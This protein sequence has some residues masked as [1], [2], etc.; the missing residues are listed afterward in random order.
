MFVAQLAERSLPTSELRGL[1]PNIGKVFRMLIFVN[2]NSEKAKIKKKGPGMASLKKEDSWRPTYLNVVLV[3]KSILF[4]LGKK[5]VGHRNLICFDPSK[6]KV[7]RTA[8]QLK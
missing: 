4:M 7:K 3:S 5:A 2:C 8:K 6:N 1:K